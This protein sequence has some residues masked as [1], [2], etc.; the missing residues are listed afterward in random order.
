VLKILSGHSS[1]GGSTTAFIN[2]TNLFNKNGIEC[3]FYGPHEWHL[4]KCNSG[5]LNSLDISKDDTII[6]HYLNIPNKLNCKKMILSIHEYTK[7]F[8]TKNINL[9]IF[10]SVQCVSEKVRAEQQ[11]PETSHIIT[12]VVDDLIPNKKNNKKFAGVIGTIHPIKNIHIS[13]ER[14]LKDKMDKIII[15]GNVGDE[16]YYNKKI[17]PYL[18]AYPNKIKHVG[19]V[20]NKQEMYDTITDVYHSS[21]F[22]TWGY[23]KAECGLTNTNYHG[24]DKTDGVLYMSNEEILTEWKKI[25]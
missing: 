3:K 11:L 9:T 6:V 16:Q 4:N 19:Y 23:I 7:I 18:K 2:L 13:I 1:Y 17:I 14:A 10:D 22:E 25:I 5:R 21:E 8:N 24:N 12:N 15:F 20:E